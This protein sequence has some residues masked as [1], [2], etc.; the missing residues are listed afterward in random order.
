M[1]IILDSL[2]HITPEQIEQAARALDPPGEDEIVVGVVQSEEAKKLWTL[3]EE[4][5]RQGLLVAHAGRFD[6]TTKEE[7]AMYRRQVFEIMTFE[8]LARDLAWA[9]VRVELHCWDRA[10][11]IRKGFT[12]VK[13]QPE[14]HLAPLVEAIAQM[15][16]LLAQTFEEEPQPKRKRKPQ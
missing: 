4:H 2:R 1:H 8:S 12:V 7:R 6:T 10:I 15:Q 13:Q 5:E 16:G 9:Q 3:A 14:A 11:G